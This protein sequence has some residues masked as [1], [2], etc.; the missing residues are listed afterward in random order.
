[1]G[2]RFLLVLSLLA[3]TVS[4]GVPRLRTTNSSLEVVAAQ[5]FFVPLDGGDQQD[6]S[7]LPGRI[8]RTEAAISPVVRFFL[9]FVQ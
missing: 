3:T 4:A 9:H 2:A 8:N 1:M 5:L 6:L 7:A